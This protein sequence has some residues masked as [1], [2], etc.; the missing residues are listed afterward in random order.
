[1]LHSKNTQQEK[2]VLDI[3]TCTAEY[4]EL[5]KQIDELTKLQKPLKEQIV[6]YAKEHIDDFDGKTL[7][8]SNGIKVEQ[9]VRYKSTFDEAKV[10][11]Q[12]LEQMVQAG[13]GSLV[14]VAID[15][16]ASLEANEN[17]ENLLEQVDY[18][19]EEMDVFR[20]CTER[21]K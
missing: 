14:S 1:M 9:T 21:K 18:F 4:A 16:K 7:P 15:A 6:Q 11:T 19:V 10:S 20:V 3:N 12:W 2:P 5:Q 8:L 13:G 17:V